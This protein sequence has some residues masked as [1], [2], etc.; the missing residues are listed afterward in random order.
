MISFIQ[1]KVRW[2]REILL[3][4]MRSGFSVSALMKAFHYHPSNII[5]HA[6]STET[7]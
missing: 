3:S 6:N 1:A 7:R 2:E 4:M 5:I